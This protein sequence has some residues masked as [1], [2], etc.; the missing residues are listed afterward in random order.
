MP[1]IESAY[2]HFT[3]TVEGS[4]TNVQHGLRASENRRFAVNVATSGEDVRDAQRLRWRVFADEG[5]ARLSSPEHGLDIDVFDAHCAHVIVR[6]TQCDKVIGTYRILTGAN[7]VA[8]GGFY[9]QTEFDISRFEH[10]QP[11]IAEL[12]RSCVHRDYRNGAVVALLWR[13]ITDYVTAQGCHILMGCASVPMTDGGQT[14]A[15]LHQELGAK[16]GAPHEYRAI[17]RNPLDMSGLSSSRPPVIPPLVKGYI[18]AGA[19]VC[20]APGWDPDFNTADF[21]MMLKLDQLD[22]RYARHYVAQ[23]AE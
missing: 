3:C 8:A 22:H 5:G 21:L 9:S 7:A 19:W 17:P 14:A 12:G 16:N 4:V 10:L 13:A 15:W 1:V 2:T 11:W 20:G 18:R 23:A 6:D